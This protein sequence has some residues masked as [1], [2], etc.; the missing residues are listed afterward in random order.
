MTSI[1]HRVAALNESQSL[2]MAARCRQLK[3]EGVDVISLSLGEPDFATPDAIKAAAHAAIDADYSHYGPVPG[4]PELREAI[5]QSING[6]QGNGRCPLYEKDDIIVSVGAKQ[7]ISNVILALINP[8]DEVI[9]PTPCWVSYSEL[10]KLAEGVPVAVPTTLETEYKITAAQL[11]AAITPKTKMLIICSPNNPTGSVYTHDELEAI[12]AVLE[13]HPQVFV[14]S[15][16]IYANI[17]YTGHHESMAQFASVRERV[18][19]INGVSKAYAMTG[20]RIGWMA[21][22][23]HELI[24]A[25]KKLQG[26]EITC[27]TTVAQKAAEAAYRGSQ[28]CVEQMRRIFEHRRNVMLALLRDI[29]GIRIAEP[30]G[31]F[32]LFPDVSSY[33]GKGNIHSSSDMADYLL[34]EAHVACVAGSAFG[35][36]KCIRFSYATDEDSIREAMRRI[37]NALSVLV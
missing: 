24:A 14:I 22:T 32:Y 30:Q 12:V 19:L 35:E 34:N 5:A 28:D 36:D 4:F 7:A 9:T 16:E 18:I 15:D 27:A 23:N 25:V 11:E 20:Y 21:S 31:A 3:A 33:Y 29:P 37:K 2:Q 6:S 26:Q 17:L 10:V 13:R 1:S 8:G